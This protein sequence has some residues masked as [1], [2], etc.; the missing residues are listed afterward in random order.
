VIYRVLT[1]IIKKSG[2]SINHVLPIASIAIN[3]ESFDV[4]E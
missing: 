2:H 1:S 3:L 4:E